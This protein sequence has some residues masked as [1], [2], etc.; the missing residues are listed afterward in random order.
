MA[1]GGVVAGRSR[2]GPF[3]GQVR[4]VVLGLFALLSGQLG[5]EVDE[6]R[7]GVGAVGVGQ[8]RGGAEADGRLG[9]FQEHA[10][11]GELFGAADAAKDGGGGGSAD[12]RLVGQ[13]A[14]QGRFGFAVTEG[15]G[16]QRG[17]DLLLH[18]LIF[19]VGQVIQQS[20][21]GPVRLEGGEFADHGHR[22]AGGLRPF[23]VLQALPRPTGVFGIVEVVG[24]L[25][26]ERDG[27]FAQR[28]QLRRRG[29]V[30]V[31]RGVAELLDERDD[32]G[33]VGRRRGSFVEEI[34]EGRPGGGE[35]GRLEGLFVRGGRGGGGS[36]GSGRKLPGRQG[37]KKND[38]RTDGHN[39]WL[40]GYTGYERVLAIIDD[41][42]GQREVKIGER[43][44]GRT[45]PGARRVCLPILEDLLW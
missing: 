37:G 32:L 31:P 10:D 7:N 25:A 4:E 42:N 43:T 33:L 8:G 2:H 45:A 15:D 16:R 14:D 30:G 3:A 1:G 35:V 5:E 39:G 13:G 44:P 34:E 38:D 6:D 40:R 26:Q 36:G 23:D 11:G 18:R 29:V 19:G 22:Q 41:S 12:R 24:G 17:F 28:G 20:L 9:V 27:R 21:D